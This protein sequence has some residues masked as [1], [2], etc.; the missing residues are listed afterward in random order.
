[1]RCQIPEREYEKMYTV[2][3]DVKKNEVDIKNVPE[4][5][6]TSKIQ[7][8]VI[9]SIGSFRKQD[10]NLYAFWWPEVKLLSTFEKQYTKEKNVFYP[11]A[12]IFLRYMTGLYCT[13]FISLLIA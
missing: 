13:L 6:V 10:M 5:T 1:M 12:K 9:L 8:Q 2:S 7:V 4:F 3:E 11:I